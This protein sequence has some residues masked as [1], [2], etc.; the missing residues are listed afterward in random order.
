MAQTVN[1]LAVQ[2]KP[3]LSWPEQLRQQGGGVFELKYR[4]DSFRKCCGRVSQPRDGQEGERN[5]QHE[6]RLGDGVFSFF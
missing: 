6:Q 4:Q 1:T 2:R 5:T 3:R